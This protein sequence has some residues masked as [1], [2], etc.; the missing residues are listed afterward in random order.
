MRPL[1]LCALPPVLLGVLLLPGAAGAETEPSAETVEGYCEHVRG[2]A[3]AQRA[4]LWAPEIFG[5]VGYLDQQTG[6]TVAP[7]RSRTDAV[8]VTAGLRYGLSGAY[9]GSAL[10]ARA[11]AD[12][13]RQQ[14]LATVT[15][16][17]G[18]IE[19]GAAR[20]ALLA[21]ARVLEKSLVEANAL[22]EQAL[23]DLAARRTTAPEVTTLRLRLDEL[24]EM[25][26]ATRRELALLSEPV[27][28]LRDV[29]AAIRAYQAADAAV[30]R[31]DARLRR[32][33]A[34]DVN[35]RFGYDR[36]LREED[37][38]VP[39]FAVVGVSYNLGGL[40]QGRANRRSAEGRRRYVAGEQRWVA[41]RI[42]RDTWRLRVL[43]RSERERL[44]QTGALLADLEAQ[45]A[46]VDGLTGDTARRYRQMLWFEW[47]KVKAEDAYLR[48][49]LE[50]LSAALD[51][52]V[53]P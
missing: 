41:E 24:R 1:S 44:E 3:A 47:V 20:A 5:N 23:A 2:A 13:R 15:R 16:S 14:A 28:S 8:R 51:E 38:S 35:V 48:A 53:V 52:L 33:R 19:S 6:I 17:L 22:F 45:L 10:S 9:E 29:P 7:D 36:F 12:C 32:A 30:E 39:L 49:H 11:D 40:W 43:Q 50:G 31:A 37:D 27:A 21:R 18:A 42:E 4:L 25:S 46:T 26:A 34:W